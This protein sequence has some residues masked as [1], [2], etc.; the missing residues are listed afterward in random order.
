MVGRQ[1]NVTLGGSEQD[2]SIECLRNSLRVVRQLVEQFS[3]H[4]TS[5][6]NSYT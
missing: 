2:L 5:G 4:L 3:H 1:D 6:L